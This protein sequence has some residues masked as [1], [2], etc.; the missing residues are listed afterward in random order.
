VSGRVRSCSAPWYLISKSLEVEPYKRAFPLLLRPLPWDWQYNRLNIISTR[1]ARVCR[2]SRVRGRVRCC[3]APSQRT[4]N[5]MNVICTWYRYVRVWR[6]RRVRG[7]VRCCSAPSLG[8]DN[9]RSCTPSVP[10]MCVGG[11]AKG[12]VSAVAPLPP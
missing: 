11:A 6:W 9:T 4:D 8:T 2:W 10:D 1:Y 5:R 3:S 12:G 7:R